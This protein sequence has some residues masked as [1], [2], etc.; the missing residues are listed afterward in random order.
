VTAEFLRWLEVFEGTF[1]CATNHATD[2][3][4][5]LMRRFAF[6]VHFQPLTMEQRLMLYAEQ[7]LG[8][9]PHEGKGLPKLD[10]QTVQRLARLDLLTAGRLCQRRPACPAA[11]PGCPSV[12]RRTGCR[13]SRQGQRGKGEDRVRVNRRRGGRV[14]Q[15][16]GARLPAAV[17]VLQTGGDPTNT[18]LRSQALA[19]SCP[20][21]KSSVRWHSCR[22]QPSAL[23]RTTECVDDALA[24][25]PG[26]TSQV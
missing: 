25:P 10:A 11:R 24:P 3:D 26:Q 5:A 18:A 23:Y 20:P 19:T 21:G 14:P 4:A 8:Q 9:Q 1:I 13:A 2:F 7:A 15:C 6:R 12:A 16:Y 22:K 17:P